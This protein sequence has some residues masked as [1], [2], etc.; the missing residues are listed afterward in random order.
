MVRSADPKRIYIARRMALISRLTSVARMN[1]ESAEHWV[2]VW[3]AE[4][5][6]RG[7]DGRTAAWWEPAW[8]WIAGQR[9]RR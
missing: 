4:A 2:A 3:E 1:P 7:L 9:G 8:E 6:R 5:A